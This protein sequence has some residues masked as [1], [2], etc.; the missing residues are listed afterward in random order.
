ME[1]FKRACMETGLAA[2][3]S[4]IFFLFTTAL[5]AVFVRAYAPTQTTI[6]IIN[7]AI[8]CLGGF[9]FSMIF[10]RRDRALIKGAA[11]G[12]LSLLIGT[13]I[14]GLI[15]G[16]RITVFFLLEILLSALFGGLGALC[17]EK[18]RKD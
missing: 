18:F 3:S 13:L 1:N 8:K 14:F 15:G 5:F 17:G 16:F 2:L 10:V 4:V 9:V 6:T 12:V 11:A 7:Q